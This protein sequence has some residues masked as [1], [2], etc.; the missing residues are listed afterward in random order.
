MADIRT[1]DDRNAGLAE[2]VESARVAQP[3]PSMST[4]LCSTSE[5]PIL[6]YVGS[7]NGRRLTVGRPF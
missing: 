3:A 7:L 5:E 6:A 2:S 1:D 4:L